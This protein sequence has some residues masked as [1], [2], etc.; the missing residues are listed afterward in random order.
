MTTAHPH[1]P[2][3]PPITILSYVAESDV[4][5]A[6]DQKHAESRHRRI[7]QYFNTGDVFKAR[8]K[9]CRTILKEK[10]RFAEHKEDSALPD[11]NYQGL[12]LY[13]EYRLNEDRKGKKGKVYRFHLMDG[14]S[15]SQTVLLERLEKEALFLIDA[16]HIFRRVEVEDGDGRTFM[17]AADGM[18]L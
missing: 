6:P 2:I 12:K 15:V 11:S 7:W 14:E 16:G 13:F 18:A 4:V 3:L 1:C 17:V 5:Y 9:A 10:D 8:S